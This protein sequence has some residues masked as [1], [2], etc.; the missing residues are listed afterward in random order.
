MFRRIE[1]LRRALGDPDRPLPSL[2][3]VA[4]LEL[5]LQQQLPGFLTGQRTALI[6]LG[7]RQAE[8]VALQVREPVGVLGGVML[9]QQQRVQREQIVDLLRADLGGVLDV[10]RVDRVRVTADL[11][12]RGAR[13]QDCE[14]RRNA[15]R[16]R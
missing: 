11:D 1:R 10:P 13:D 5:L 7:Y 3:V 2:L 12:R 16:G 6:D 4:A 15:R 9:T 14:E 8:E